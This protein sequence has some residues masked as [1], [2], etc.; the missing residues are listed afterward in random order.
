MH[1]K[2]VK[3]FLTYSQRFINAIYHYA[4]CTVLVSRKM[5]GSKIDPC[6]QGIYDLVVFQKSKLSTLGRGCLKQAL[7]G[8]R[9]HKL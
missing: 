9:I 7:H 2:S 5:D 6:S 8:E 1:V 3:Q 4:L